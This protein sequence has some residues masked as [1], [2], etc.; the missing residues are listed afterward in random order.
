M[1]MPPGWA[2][3]GSISASNQGV[4][5][6]QASLPSS[7]VFVCEH[8]DVICRGRRLIDFAARAGGDCNRLQLRRA[9]RA[10]VR[11]RP[12]VDLGVVRQVVATMAGQTGGGDT[13]LVR[14][15]EPD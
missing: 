6:T 11:I 10:A 15:H 13:P 8:P 1:T 9:A 7:R 4:R 2:N 3:A 5:R 14:G 12:L